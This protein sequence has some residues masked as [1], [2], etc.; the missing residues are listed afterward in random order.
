[1]APSPDAIP[2]VVVSQSPAPLSSPPL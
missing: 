2:S 1:V